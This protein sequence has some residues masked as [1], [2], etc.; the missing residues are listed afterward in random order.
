MRR[1]FLSDGAYYISWYEGTRER[2]LV[3]VFYVLIDNS[4]LVCHKSDSA[5]LADWYRRWTDRKSP[6][7]ELRRK[8]NRKP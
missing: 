5:A 3:I 2:P 4:N 7:Q 6:V 1:R 8:S